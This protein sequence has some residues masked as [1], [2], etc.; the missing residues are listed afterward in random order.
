[1][2]GI[3]GIYNFGSG[4]PAE[5]GLVRGMTDLLRHRGPDDRGLFASGALCIGMSRLSIIDLEGGAQPLGSEDGSIQVVCNGEIYNHL[6]LRRELESRGHRF[7]SRSDAE[8]LVHAYEEFGDDLLSRLNGMYAFA[9]WDGPRRRL[10]LARDRLGIKPLYYAFT[11]SGLVF[12]SELKALMLHP[13]VPSDLDA[14]A[15]RQYLAWEFI[16][17]PATP[18]LAARKLRPA[19]FLVASPD[20]ARQ[21]SYWRL[22]PGPPVRSVDEAAEGVLWHLDRSVRLQ[23]FAD[24]PV[25][26]FLSGGVDS[27]VIAASLRAAGKDPLH[28]FSVGFEEDSFNEA[29]HAQHAADSL[30]TVHREVRL[31][32][33][34]ADLVQEVGDFLD[35]PFADSSILPT[36]LVSKLARRHVKVVLSGDG[37]DELFGGYERYKADQLSRWYESVPVPLRALLARLGPR[38]GGN[39]IHKG[40]SWQE[41]IGRLERALTLSPSLQHARW[42]VRTPPEMQGELLD[43]GLNGGDGAGWMEPLLTAFSESPFEGRLTRQLDVDVRTSLADDILF[44]LDRA[45]MAAS[46]EARVPFLDHELVEYAFRIPDRWKLRRLVGKWILRRAFKGRAPIRSLQRRK[47]GFSVPVAA[48]LRGDLRE[49]TCDTLAPDRLREHGLLDSGTVARTLHEHLSGAS[50]HSR[51]LWTVLMLQIWFEKHRTPSRS[52]DAGSRQRFAHAEA[53]I[54]GTESAHA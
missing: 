35:E 51:T 30:W 18:Y 33:R 15:L 19:S 6:E 45:S 41:R 53:E 42:M 48:W 9:L 7:R 37:A 29:D 22:E 44:K 25:G 39:G 54:P 24:V 3:A 10:L 26:A 13:E 14:A 20:G 47:S 38:E 27:T 31:R 28:T 43:G 32:S 40:G 2:C 1:M 21:Q 11:P 34:C 49:L 4:A 16:P 36:Y 12:A 50:D 52:L 17:A 23:M 8:V 46:L 5:P